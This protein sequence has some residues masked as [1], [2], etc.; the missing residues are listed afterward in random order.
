MHGSDFN[1]DF[2]VTLDNAAAPVRYNYRNAAELEK[3][4]DWVDWAGEQPGISAC[5]N[6]RIFHTYSSYARGGDLLFGTYNWLDLTALGRQEDWNSPLGAPMAIYEL[7]SPPRRVR[8]PAQLARSVANEG[9]AA[10]GLL[11]ST[12]IFFHDVNLRDR[13]HRLGMRPCRR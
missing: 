8:Q 10:L 1:Y 6:D 11:R 9:A 7:G 3:N 4:P 12:A 13:V 5:D 2:H